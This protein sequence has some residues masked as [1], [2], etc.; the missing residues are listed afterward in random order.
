MAVSMSTLRCDGP[1]CGSDHERRP[2]DGGHD[3]G[4]ARQDRLA[5]RV[6]KPR[7]ADQSDVARM[8]FVADLVEA[9][10]VLTDEPTVDPRHQRRLASSTEPTAHEWPNDHHPAHRDG[11]GQDSLDPDR[12]VGDEE[13]QQTSREG[14]GR[15]EDS[16]EGRA[17]QF[18]HKQRQRRDE[19]DDVDQHDRSL[20][21]SCAAVVMRVR[22]SAVPP[23]RGGC[24]YPHRGHAVDP[25]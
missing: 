9:E 20:C 17:G 21:P 7:L 13:G 4:C 14:A 8:E 5:F 15:Q 18:E 24:Q 3:D 11:D 6:R 16:K 25:E 19:P 23:S 1:R 2:A 10:R 22:G 12:A